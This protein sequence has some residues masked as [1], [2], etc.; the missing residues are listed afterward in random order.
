MRLI[1]NNCLSQQYRKS[2]V[3]CKKT[4]SSIGLDLWVGCIED[5]YCFFQKGLNTLIKWRVLFVGEPS[6][7]T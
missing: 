3:N 4:I 6:I 2:T 1:I 7:L 5:G